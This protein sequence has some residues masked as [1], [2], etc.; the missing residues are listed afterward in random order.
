MPTRQPEQ[1]RFLVWS[2]EHRSWWRANHMGYTGIIG[3]AGRYTR[4]EAEA[5]VRN[6]NLHTDPND[7]PNEVMVL[8]PE[9]ITPEMR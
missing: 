5:I 6:A 3:Q 1:E 7:T 8:A 9:A 2:N 4:N